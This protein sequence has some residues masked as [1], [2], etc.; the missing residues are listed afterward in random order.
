[1]KTNI[2]ML[3][4]LTFA[5]F[6]CT[7]KTAQEPAVPAASTESVATPAPLTR[8]PSPAGARVF[9]ITPADGA[10]VSNPITI[11]FGVEGMEIVKAGTEQPNSGHHHLLIDTELPDL[12]LPIPADEH[13]VHFGDGRTTTEIV[14][15]PG[16][17]TLQMLLG[18]YRHVPH[19]PPLMSDVI[20][21]TVE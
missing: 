16:T 8:L 15:P 21:V 5:L 12:S 4:V 7:E 9:F 1:M 2:L 20:T 19:D 18:D 11:E 14:L 3:G 6:A 10:T 17:H 13:H